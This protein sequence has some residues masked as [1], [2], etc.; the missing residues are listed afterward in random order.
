MKHLEADHNKEFPV[1]SLVKPKDNTKDPC[2]GIH[3]CL[4]ANY[5]IPL[6][7]IYPSVVFVR[8]FKVSENSYE[9]MSEIELNSFYEKVE[10]INNDQ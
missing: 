9:F 2:V 1:G 4:V 10:P 6:E 5:F 7:E 8:L 3:N